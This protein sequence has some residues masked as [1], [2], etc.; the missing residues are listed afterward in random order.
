MRTLRLLGIVAASAIGQMA[1]VITN[2]LAVQEIKYIATQISLKD[3]F[4][5]LAV[6]FG[7]VN[8][9]MLLKLVILH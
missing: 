1:E 5:G 2:Q 9:P 3:I 7:L 4:F 8:V 6:F